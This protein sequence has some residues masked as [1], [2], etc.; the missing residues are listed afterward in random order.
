MRLNNVFYFFSNFNA[1]NMSKVKAVFVLLCKIRVLEVCL[2]KL[3]TPK[4]LC[5][6]I[7]NLLFSYGDFYCLSLI[8]TL[9]LRQRVTKRGTNNAPNDG[10][11]NGNYNGNYKCS[12]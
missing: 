4:L 9:R 11:Y 3:L 12:K 1:E 6:D 2:W 5:Y 10:N 8:C 7:N